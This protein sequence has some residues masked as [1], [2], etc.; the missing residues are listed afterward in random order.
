MSYDCTVTVLDSAF[1][2][3]PGTPYIHQLQEQPASS[4]TISEPSDSVAVTAGLNYAC[5]QRSFTVI[6]TNTNK[7]PD[8][9][10]VSSNNDLTFLLD[11]D[12]V[13]KP[14]SVLGSYSIQIDI[15]LAD[16]TNISPVSITVNIDIVCPDDPI[17]YDKV[18][19]VPQSMLNPF[20]F[21]IS[22][23]PGT[24]K[25]LSLEQYELRPV[26][27]GFTAISSVYDQT[28]AQSADGFIS[29]DYTKGQ[30]N[31]SWDGIAMDRHEYKWSVTLYDSSE[32]LQ[33]FSVLY[34]DLSLVNC[35]QAVWPT[36]SNIPWAWVWGNGPEI[37]DI[38]PIL[39]DLEQ[40][41]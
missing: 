2:T 24:I 11:V 32:Q 37:I 1:Y 7:A 12:T 23:D 18:D 3:D 19:G 5:G 26:A 17:S 30:V 39:T 16:Y 25:S 36:Q 20:V 15:G 31:I 6:D 41:F 8:W 14:D 22:Q 28:S 13:A 21:D 38:P 33:T 34:K 10:S 4:F 40:N 29:T 27:C 9:L 35:T